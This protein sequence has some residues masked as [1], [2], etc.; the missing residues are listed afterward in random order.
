MFKLIPILSL[1]ALSC[2]SG[3]ITPDSTCSQEIAGVWQTQKVH[4]GDTVDYTLEI[5]GTDEP[6]LFSF[7]FRAQREGKKVHETYGDLLTINPQ[8]VS[9]LHMIE[10]EIRRLLFFTIDHHG[11]EITSNTPTLYGTSKAKVWG[12]TLYIWDTQYQR[13]KE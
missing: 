11:T 8:K 4:Q 2:D 9:D 5:T 7:L 6:C 12:E 13:K 3:V 10:I 1:F